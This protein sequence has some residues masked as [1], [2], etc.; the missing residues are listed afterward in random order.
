MKKEI[1]P[2]TVNVLEEISEAEMEAVEA[3]VDSTI[4]NIRRS[5]G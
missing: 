3:V 5:M 2:D 1:L 4:A